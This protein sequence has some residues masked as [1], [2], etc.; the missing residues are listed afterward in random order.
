[1]KAIISS[2]GAV[3]VAGV[4]TGCGPADNA[5]TTA[6]RQPLQTWSTQ[7]QE[8]ARQPLPHEQGQ[9]LNNPNAAPGATAPNEGDE[10][11][12]L[13][14][15]HGRIVLK[16]FPE[17]APRHVENFKTLA[18]KGFYDGT[19]FHRVI[20]GFMIQGGDPNTRNARARETHG[21]GGPDHR[22]D[23]EF[24]AIPHTRGILSM[25]RTQDPNSAGSQFFI[26]VDR[27][28]SLDNQYTVFGQVVD[29]MDAVDKIV[30]LPRDGNDNPHP[31]NEA[32]IKT[33]RIEKWPV[34][35]VPG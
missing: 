16:F 25:A 2:L 23:Q 31:A 10:V 19:R 33:V 3:A 13:E 29:G 21:M 20:P 24:N 35:G 6:D 4:L 26:T 27:A 17:V 8:P 9:P 5:A 1:M 22:V 30:S 15:N 34:E 14:T 28:A 11:A 18:R 32:V 7:D 12:I